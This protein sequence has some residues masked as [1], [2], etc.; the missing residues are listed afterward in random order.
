MH[1]IKIRL[2]EKGTI[3]VVDVLG[4]LLYADTTPAYIQ[5]YSKNLLFVQG[6]LCQRN[7]V[8]LYTLQLTLLEEPAQ[9][10]QCFFF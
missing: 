3:M 7:L 5:K 10:E 8:V 4:Q 2:V 9:T 1:P 6:D